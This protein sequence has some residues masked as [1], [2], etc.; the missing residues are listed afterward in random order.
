MKATFIKWFHRFLVI[1]QPTLSAALSISS[2]IFLARH[3]NL[4]LNFGACCSL[5]CRSA[6]PFLGRKRGYRDQ[7][8]RKIH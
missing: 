7:Y 3:F 8:P 1:L 5:L 2:G 6:S 4:F